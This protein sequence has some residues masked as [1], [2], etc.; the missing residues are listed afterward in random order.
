MKKGIQYF[1]KEYLER[2]AE[3]T[4]DEILQFIEDYR[5]LVFGVS[6]KCKPI[7]LKVEPTLLALFKRK[8]EMMGVPYQTQIKNLMREFVKD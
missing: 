7:S 8:A 3:L 2:S 6:E 4:P 5:N 1:T